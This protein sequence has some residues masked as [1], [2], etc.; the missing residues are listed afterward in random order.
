MQKFRE[1]AGLGVREFARL[2][3]ERI[4]EGW[5]HS[6]LGYVEKGEKPL[7]ARDLYAIADVLNVTV[8]DLLG[9]PQEVNLGAATVRAD[10]I[11]G[12][13]S[14][15]V[16]VEGMNHL[17]AAADALAKV[18]NEWDRYRQEAEAARRLVGESP[19]LREQ[20][21]QYQDDASEVLQADMQALHADAVEHAR[22]LAKD[23]HGKVQPSPFLEAPG[24]RSV[25]A[26]STP[27][28]EAARDVLGTTRLREHPWRNQRAKE[29]GER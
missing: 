11:T 27:A 14:R 9:M 2:V 15:L 12:G 21:E 6:A 8:A 4:G 19:A 28:M 24:T 5:S 20:V 26:N 13:P 16:E 3:R 25:I 7:R 29:E 17:R 18:R 23:P 10:A 1:D 22:V